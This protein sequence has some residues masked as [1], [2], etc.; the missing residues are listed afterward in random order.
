MTPVDETLK[1]AAD[2]GATA[3][4]FAAGTIEKVGDL[5]LVF[6][7]AALTS[8]EADGY[9]LHG[10]ITQHHVADA[11]WGRWREIGE[12]H[13]RG[14]YEATWGSIRAALRATAPRITGEK[15]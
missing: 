6:L 15:K 11:F 14:Y 4:A 12:T 1:R 3:A 10:P 13:K 7:V 9:E 8:L 5:N 2:T